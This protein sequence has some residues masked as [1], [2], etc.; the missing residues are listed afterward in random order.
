[1]CRKEKETIHHIISGCDALAPTKYL[2]RHDN[3]CK[4]IHVLLTNEHGIDNQMTSWY[5]H[6]PRPVVENDR[7]KI[8][9][10]FQ[11][12]TDHLRHKSEIIILDKINNQANIIVVAILSDYRI[13]QKR[14][15]KKLHGIH[16]NKNIVETIQ[17]PNYSDHHWCHGQQVQTIGQGH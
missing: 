10:N 15:E 16:R 11:I 6:Q 13:A 14:L 1:M 3:V 5:Q 12:H 4:Y 2:E 9:W 17:G 7:I 8:L